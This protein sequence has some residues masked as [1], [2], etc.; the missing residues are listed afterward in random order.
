MSAESELKRHRTAVQG[1]QKKF[2]QVTG[3]DWVSAAPHPTPTI[4]TVTELPEH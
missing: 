4:R 3:A 2:C 1:R